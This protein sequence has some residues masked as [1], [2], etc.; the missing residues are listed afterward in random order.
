M[1][2]GF[3]ALK[4]AAFGERIS[5][6]KLRGRQLAGS[7]PDEREDPTNGDGAEN[8]RW[9][10]PSFGAVSIFLSWKVPEVAGVAREGGHY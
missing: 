1:P 2:V 10:F 4:S 5:N 3:S 8:V 6:G 7:W 9:F